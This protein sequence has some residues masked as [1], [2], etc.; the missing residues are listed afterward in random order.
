[1]TESRKWAVLLAGEVWPGARLREQLAGAR[2][3]AADAGMRHAEALGVEPEVWIGDFDSA[4]EAQLARH[5]HVPRITHPAEKDM[6]DGALAIAHALEQGAEELLLIGALGGRMD[7][8]MA[9]MLQLAGLAERGL[10]A[11]ASSGREE[12]H[13]LAAG[14]HEI[15]LPAGTTFSLI[16]FGPLEGVHIEGA[17]WP[18]R[19]E[20]LAFASTR[21]ISNVALE[22][23][24]VR[25]GKGRG[26]LI[27][28]PRPQE[29]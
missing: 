6:T 16:G 26:V 14:A 1:M 21:P 10:R 19:G 8:A 12:A 28:H 25:I 7:H 3:V 23:L 20:R 15:S 5:A 22:P 4:A 18:L 11:L 17:K 2:V 13:G 9:H 24:R 29:A 27:A